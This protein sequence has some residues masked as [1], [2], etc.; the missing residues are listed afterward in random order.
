MVTCVLERAC[1]WLQGYCQENTFDY[2][3]QLQESNCT[4]NLLPSKMECK[5]ARK[6]VIS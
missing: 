5:N 4:L 1:I 2:I 3:K 6:M